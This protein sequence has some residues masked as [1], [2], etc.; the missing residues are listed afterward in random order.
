MTRPV[1][2]SHPA[3]R[4]R[5]GSQPG[6]DLD[7]VLE[8][9]FATA[10]TDDY[11]GYSKHD[12]LNAPWLERLAGRSRM[13]RLV[14]T[15]AVM[16][17]PIDVRGLVG[18][19][20]AR[21]AKGSRSS[22]APSLLACRRT[23]SAV[24]AVEAASLLDWLI[25]HPSPALE[26]TGL[27]GLAWGYPYPWQDVGFFA[28]R[29]FPNRVVTSFV[30]Q[31]LLDAYEALGEPRYL[32]AAA[33][34]VDFHTARTE[35]AV[36]GRPPSLRQLRARRRRSTWIVMDVSALVGA[37]AARLGSITADARMV[38][39]GGRLV[40]YVV[41][42]QTDEGAW[43][44]SEPP[45]ASHITHDNYHTGFILDAIACY[46][47]SSGSTEFSDAY[48]RGIDFY[49]RRLF[50]PDGAARFM[51]DQ[52]Y[53]IDI[54]GCAQGILTF[55]LQQ[56]R[57]GEG[58]EM[59]TQGARLDACQHVGPGERLVLLPEA[60]RHADQDPRTALV[61][62]LDVAGAG[63]VPGGARRRRNRR[64]R[65]F[66]GRELAE[67]PGR[68]KF[69]R[70]Y[71]RILGAPANGLR[72]RLRRVLPATDGEYE[73]ILDAGCGGGVF[74]FEL[75]KRHPQA[76]VIGVDME[77]DLVDRANTM[78]QR[79]GLTNCRFEQRDVT[80]LPYDRAFDLV[81]SVDNLEHVEDD[82]T[83]MRDLYAALRPGGTLV[84]HVPGY[85]R[86][87]LMFGRR[88]NFDVPG[89]VRPGYHAGELVERLDKAG[90]EV[91]EQH[92]TYGIAGDVH[93]Q[94]LLP[95]H[96]RRSA[97]Q[98]AVRGGVPAAARVCR[99]SASSPTRA[100]GPACS[101]SPSGRTARDGMRILI[102]IL[103]PAHVHFFRN[104]HHEMSERGH[105]LKITARA[106]DRSLE[107]LDR[108]GLPYE[109]L[110]AQRSGAAGMVSEMTQRTMRL[111]KVAGAFRP[112]VMT[113]IMGPSIAVAGTL[114]RVPAV[115]FYD[116]E[117]AKQTNW[118]V[119]PL[120]HSVVTPDCYQGKV[121][122]NH[123]T[124]A[125]YHELAYLHP[126][127][128]SPDPERLAA[129]GVAPEEP[130]SI[131]RF[132]SWQAVHD[133]KETGLSVAQKRDL[134]D[135]LEQHGRVLDLLRGA[136]AP[137]PGG[138]G[139][140]RAGGGHPPPAG[141]RPAGRR[142]VG[143]DVVG[144]RGARRAGGVHRD[145]RARLHRRR[146]AP[147][148]TGPPLHR[149]SRWI[150]RVATIDELFSSSPRELGRSARGSSPTRST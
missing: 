106:K 82:V 71:A 28:P 138:Q 34:V 4:W 38:A 47:D 1:A 73:S 53:P 9:V 23:G 110:S 48:D 49:A 35:D 119:Y 133:R 22:P 64:M 135:Q 59:A 60:P 80:R 94:H 42:K 63:D 128:F 58:L 96:R 137:R 149:G 13:P 143:D 90:F 92:A 144:G 140:H 2:D 54:H 86:R 6:L 79:A 61:P 69:E 15:Q 19:R 10:R 123:V 51:S 141:L 21:N 78:A 62:G 124:Y 57:G 117:F 91:V 32:D 142:R 76:T 31:A 88:V 17:S 3:S 29:H 107:L 52:H 147:L 127:R 131:V 87:W 112:D 129:F 105:E 18:V 67:D 70:L 24:D 150:R 37:L 134:V 46:S 98:G 7:G 89:H 30:G 146:G 45:S 68:S 50:E 72:I 130:Y 95:R 84:V 27:P 33:E 41:S 66:P 100:G 136:I 39:E 101:P 121:R 126:N 26:T 83:A 115:V 14:A 145:D 74:S 97:A 36:R 85:E 75:A 81:V 25:E 55:S 102:D 44:Y 122:G 43:F 104:F 118:F 148:R 111:N 40:R 12:A 99:G 93:Q 16:R 8:R 108:Y 125:G 20:K 109:Q 113:G 5:P 114:R 11:A 103:H 116:T 132:V 77:A 120:A 56:R 139:G 65:G